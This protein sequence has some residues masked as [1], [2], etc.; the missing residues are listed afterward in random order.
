M[1]SFEKE[2]RFSMA[3]KHELIKFKDGEL[4]LD[5][6]VSPEQETV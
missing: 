1:Q 6:D 5:V 3:T 4:V 2:E